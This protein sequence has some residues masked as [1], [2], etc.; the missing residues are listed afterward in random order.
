MSLNHTTETIY[1]ALKILIMDL[2]KA[3]LTKHAEILTHRI[4]KVAW[5]SRYELFE[6]LI[7]ILSELEKAHG[8]SMSVKL[9]AQVQ[10]LLKNLKEVM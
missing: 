6:E 10:A 1:P 4:T 2:T 5:T 7:K 8:M 9:S 3:G